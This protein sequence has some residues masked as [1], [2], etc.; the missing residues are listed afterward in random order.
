MTEKG[1]NFGFLDRCDD[2]VAHL[3]RQAERYV[4]TDPDSC[5]FKLRLMIET[6][7]KRLVAMSAPDM[8][9]MTRLGLTGWRGV[10]RSKRL[11]DRSSSLWGWLSCSDECSW[12]A[13][14]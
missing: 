6:M 4:Y 11:F 8:D 10:L 3:A 9:M 7:A 1:T 12:S 14:S 2:R 5:L 13:S